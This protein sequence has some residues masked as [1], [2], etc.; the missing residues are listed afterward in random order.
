MN[1]EQVLE[2]IR[3]QLADILEISPEGISESSSFS[4]DLNA[5]PL[6][7]IEL[8]ESLEEELRNQVA[9][10]RIDDEDLEDLRTVRDAVDYVT[11][12][13]EAT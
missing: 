6:A 10:F 5:D 1:R 3:L 2:L 12:K 13:L 8:V 4:G 7:L 9:D 11:A